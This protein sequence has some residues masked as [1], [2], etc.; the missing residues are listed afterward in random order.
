[1]TTQKR[2]KVGG[3]VGTN[4]E[5]YEG[6]KFLPSTEKPRRHGSR[7]ARPRK[8][9][10]EPYVWVTLEPG[11]DRRPLLSIVGTGAMW[12]DRRDWTK[13]VEPFMPAFEFL[14]D[15]MYNG[16]TLANVKALCDRWNAGER[17]M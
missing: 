8:V 9:E 4:G 5:Y 11:D 13:G 3:E 1:M 15:R 7:P 10:V 2:A 17:W 6:G 12:I 14:G 16:E